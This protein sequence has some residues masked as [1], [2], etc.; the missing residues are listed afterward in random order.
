[1]SLCRGFICFCAFFHQ[2]FVDVFHGQ[3]LSA[4]VLALHLASC[5]FP[6]YECIYC[7]RTWLCSVKI[8]FFGHYIPN[9]FRSFLT[10][11]SPLSFQFTFSSVVVVLPL[12]P[13]YFKLDSML[14]SWLLFHAP[15][16][17]FWIDRVLVLF[18]CPSWLSFGSFSFFLALVLLFFV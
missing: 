4:L 16:I 13:L 10:L 5:L 15:F 1:M 8:S 2:H 7:Y 14:Q 18:S 12:E 6:V 3:C 11:F 9:I 17:L